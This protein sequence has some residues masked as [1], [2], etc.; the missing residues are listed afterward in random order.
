[1]LR[2][3]QAFEFKHFTKET[4]LTANEDKI[5]LK[6][7]REMLKNKPKMSDFSDVYSEIEIKRDEKKVSEIKTSFDKEATLRSEILAAVLQEQIEMSE[8]LGE[9]AFTIQTTDYDD[10][11]NHTDFIIEL[12]NG[13]NESD[14]LAID[15]TVGTNPDKLNNKIKK[16]QKELDYGRGT[17]IKYYNSEINPDNKGR[18]NDIP[19]FIISMENEELSKLCNLTANTIGENKITGSN[20]KLAESP[21]QLSILENIII[22]IDKQIKY[23]NKNRKIQ[24]TIFSRLERL[25]IKL[26]EIIENKKGQCDQKDPQLAIDVVNLENYF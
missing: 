10:Y 24:T 6:K 3:D 15:V 8:W 16:I 14:K 9:N 17:S 26:N 21:L 1:M 13:E 11:I 19:S 25:K 12:D 2:P 4:P 7:V 22:Q 23:L 20:Q 18:Q 5:Y